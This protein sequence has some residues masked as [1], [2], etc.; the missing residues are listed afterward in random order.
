MKWWLCGYLVIL[1]QYV[2]M[3]DIA[4]VPMSD[5][6]ILK[7]HVCLLVGWFVSLIKWWTKKSKIILIEMLRI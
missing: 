7:I 6:V 4:Y 3:S 5:L 2:S 1:C